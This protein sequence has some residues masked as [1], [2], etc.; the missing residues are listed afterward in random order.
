M[1]PLGSNTQIAANFLIRGYYPLLGKAVPLCELS[2]NGKSAHLDFIAEV[3]NQ[4]QNAPDFAVFDDNIM[5]QDKAGFA[6]VNLCQSDFIFKYI[7]P[8]FM[9]H[10]SM[11]YAIARKSGVHLSKGDFDGLHS[12]P[13]GFSFVQ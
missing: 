8:N 9:F 7:V 1:F 13:P 4:L 6:E 12:Y 5:L 11:V 2:G 3:H 10:M